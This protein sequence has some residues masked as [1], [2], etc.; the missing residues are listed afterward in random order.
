MATPRSIA[1]NRTNLK[2]GHWYQVLRIFQDEIPY[3]HRSNLVL[4][5]KD[6]PPICL[7]VRLPKLLKLREIFEQ[8]HIAIKQNLVFIRFLGDYC[9]SVQFKILNETMLM[10]ECLET[11]LHD[12]AIQP[13]LKSIEFKALSPYH[14][15]AVTKLVRGPS[16]VSQFDL[17]LELDWELKVRAPWQIQYHTSINPKYLD[18]LEAASAALNLYLMSWG[19]EHESVVLEYHGTRMLLSGYFSYV[20]NKLRMR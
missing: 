7:P 18:T 8:L 16:S 4:D 3:G 10:Q 1:Q 14:W 5:D 12:V 9:H 2:F 19:D 13:T 11:L 20:K 6:N 15:H 17:Y